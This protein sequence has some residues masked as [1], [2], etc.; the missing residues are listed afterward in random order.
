V[1]CLTMGLQGYLAHKKQP[2]PKD[3]HMTLGLVLLHGPTEGVFL[4]SEVPLYLSEL[5]DDEGAHPNSFKSAVVRTWH[6]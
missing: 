1:K 6:V 3:H 5:L 4:M 2:P